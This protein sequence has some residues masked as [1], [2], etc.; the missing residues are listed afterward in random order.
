MAPE[1]RKSVMSKIQ[2]ILAEDVLHRTELMLRKGAVSLIGQLVCSMLCTAAALVTLMSAAWLVGSGYLAL[3]QLPAGA[4]LPATAAVQ[5]IVSA[6]GGWA[7]AAA[8]A[9]LAELQWLPRTFLQVVALVPQYLQTLSTVVAASLGIVVALG[10]GFCVTY[11]AALGVG[12]WF[13][14][15]LGILWHPALNR[16]VT[17]AA[18]WR[19]PPSDQAA[20]D[21][22]PK[23]GVQPAAKQRSAG[24]PGRGGRTAEGTAPSTT[25]S[26]PPATAITTTTTTT[27]GQ[28]PQ[29]VSDRQTMRTTAVRRRR[30]QQ[31]QQRGSVAGASVPA[32]QARRGL[33]G[34]QHVHPGQQGAEGGVNLTGLIN[35][36]TWLSWVNSIAAVKHW[37]LGI[38]ITRIPTGP[39]A[40]RVTRGQAN[41]SAATG[42]APDSSASRHVDRQRGT[43]RADSRQGQGQEELRQHGDDGQA[44]DYSSPARPARSDSVATRTGATPDD[45]ATVDG[46]GYSDPAT[47]TRDQL[48]G[49]CTAAAPTSPAIST[50]TSSSSDSAGSSGSP[51]ATAHIRL[52]DSASSQQMCAQKKASRSRGRAQGGNRKDEDDGDLT[53]GKCRICWER[54]RKVCWCTWTCSL[55]DMPRC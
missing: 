27:S 6:A 13:M 55:S 19:S 38:I 9:I 47:T 52:A 50:T 24:Q 12:G 11:I 30:Q 3:A 37:L 49:G 48:S 2:L 44:Q 18:W 53:G 22:A 32:H 8:S 15:T 23:K 4:S 46:T 14:L 42:G 5:S 35:T 20:H 7:M 51:H 17:A 28:S 45:P 39:A 10:L 54:K 34:H 41:H 29:R 21:T 16:R 25:A 1:Q 33:Q 36:R 26:S 40:L 31:Q 43:I